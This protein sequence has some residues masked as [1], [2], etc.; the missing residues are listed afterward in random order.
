[1]AEVAS[2][3][4]KQWETIC[5]ETCP[6]NHDD[7]DEY[8][9][10]VIMNVMIQFSHQFMCNNFATVT[11]DEKGFIEHWMYWTKLTDNQQHQGAVHDVLGRDG[12][13]G[14]PAVDWQDL[15]S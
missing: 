2:L 5:S 13:C 6:G 14:N 10:V 7:D 12:L 15:S 1:M 11:E 8:C 9:M 3:G 4:Q